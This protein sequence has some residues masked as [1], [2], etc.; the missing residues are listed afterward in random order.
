[1]LEYE[2]WI[3]LCDLC[4]ETFLFPWTAVNMNRRRGL[5]GILTLCIALTAWLCDAL[6]GTFCPWWSCEALSTHP[7]LSVNTSCDVCDVIFLHKQL[8]VS[9]WCALWC[10]QYYQQLHLFWVAPSCSS[11]SYA[12][13][14][15]TNIILLGNFLIFCSLLFMPFQFHVLSYCHSTILCHYHY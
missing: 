9:L 3:T 12:V 15:H 10:H 5:F 14:Y 1:M 13:W 11:V 7:C 8:S 2:P 4:C 6:W